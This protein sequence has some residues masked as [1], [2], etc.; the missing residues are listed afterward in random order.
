MKD[1]GE[2]STSYGCFGRGQNQ[3]SWTRW[4]GHDF[5]THEARYWRA[6][7]MSQ[8]NGRSW[9]LKSMRVRNE[10]RLG[11]PDSKPRYARLCFWDDLTLAEGRKI[12]GVA[13]CLSF[14][15][16]LGSG[17]GVEH[18][19]ESRFTKRA[20]WSDGAVRSWE[21]TL[22]WSQ[23]AIICLT[24]AVAKYLL[25]CHFGGGFSA[26]LSRFQLLAR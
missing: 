18:F 20:Y 2:N 23:I 12:P 11:Y 21:S 22:L 25:L 14:L 26:C 8:A 5:T 6:A 9:L 3:F 17:I 24:G 7:D 1:I 16:L 15:V 10:V 19:V 13:P 4:I